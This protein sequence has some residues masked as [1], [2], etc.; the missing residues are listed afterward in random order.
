LG[1]PQ[2][3][4]HGLSD[5]VVPASMSEEYRRKACEAGDAAVYAPIEGMGHRDLI[6]PSR[7]SWSIVADYLERLLSV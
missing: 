4:V 5:A 7:E 6:D 2:L 3:L 1:I